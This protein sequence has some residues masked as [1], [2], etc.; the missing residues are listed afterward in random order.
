MENKD[1]QIKTQEGKIYGPVETETLKKWIQEKRILAEDS[2]WDEN[3]KEWINIKSIPELKDFFKTGGK[4]QEKEGKELLEVKP[5]KE[6]TA[7][8][9]VTYDDDKSLLTFQLIADAW[10]AMLA[11]GIWFIIGALLLMGIVSLAGSAI[12]DFIP[13]IGWFASLIISAS[14][15]LGWQ[16]YS[17]KVARKE[18]VNVGTIFE[19]FKGKYIWL[20]LGAMLLIGLLTGLAGLISCG[21]WGFYLSLAYLLSYFFIFD[22]NRGPWEAMKASF[23]ATKGYKWRIM[24][25]Q[26]ICMLIGM[27][28]LGVG[29]LVTIP[30]ANIAIASLYYRIRTDRISD[31]H[32]HTSFAEYLIVLIPFVLVIA[33]IVGVVFMIINKQLPLLLPQIEQTLKNLPRNI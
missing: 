16:A 24:A 12:A 8:I 23:D 21:I 19:G 6:K 10:R 20:A 32:A 30:L 11:K 14:L 9:E 17:L 31:K 13:F 22:E 26:M 1:W 18:K 5:S 4:T 33:L 15:T 7:T 3:K 25:V 29:L 28:C 2:V 27:L